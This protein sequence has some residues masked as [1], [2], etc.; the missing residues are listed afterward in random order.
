MPY[1]VFGSLGHSVSISRPHSCST[2]WPVVLLS[3][4]QDLAENNWQPLEGATAPM[5]IPLESDIGYM[6]KVVLDV[7]EPGFK[8]IHGLTDHVVL[9]TR[10]PKCTVT[11]DGE[12]FVPFLSQWNRRRGWT[13]KRPS[14]NMSL[15]IACTLRGVRR[16]PPPLPC[17]A[18]LQVS[19]WRARCCRQG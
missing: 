8:P 2:Q 12:P 17:P 7:D 6:L 10:M 4:H 9:G 14:A 13:R 15:S 5:Y 16:G 3:P 11:L 1:I 19:P 18:A